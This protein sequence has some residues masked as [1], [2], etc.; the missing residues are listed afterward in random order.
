MSD[1][2]GFLAPIYQP[3]ST[4]VFGEDLVAANSVFSTFSRGKHSLIIGGGDGVAYRDW[5]RDFSGEY[6]DTSLKMAELA[7]QNLRR[8]KVRVSCGSWPGAGEFDVVMLPF[9]LDTLPDQA[10]EKLID[11]IADSLNPGGK[12]ILSDFFSPKTCSQR[13]LQGLMIAG[14][15]VFA[16]HPRTDLPDFERFFEE[17]SWRLLDEQTWRKGWVRARVYGRIGN[18]AY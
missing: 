15:R 13:L 10:I 6:W 5:D 3:L 8:S 14:F 2:Y 17:K 18:S 16:K 7:K 9:V 4:L 11:Q 12:V 1:T